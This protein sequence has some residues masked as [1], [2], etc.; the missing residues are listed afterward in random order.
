MS[1]GNQRPTGEPVPY[2]GKP[3]FRTG[4]TS[5]LRRETRL[6]CWLLLQRW[7]PLIPSPRHR[8]CIARIFLNIAEMET[9]VGLWM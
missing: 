7:L 9:G 8:L 4:L 1:S 5:H 2:G 6:Q 3:A